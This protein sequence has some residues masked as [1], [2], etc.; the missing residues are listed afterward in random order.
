MNRINSTLRN[1]AVLITLVV[2]ALAVF[3]LVSRQTE[4]EPQ[5]IAQATAVVPTTSQPTPATVVPQS[6]TEPALSPMVEPTHTPFTPEVVTGK[7]TL[8]TPPP[9]PPTIGPGLLSNYQLE[10]IARLSVSDKKQ[11]FLGGW[12]ADSQNLFVY[13]IEEINDI[14]SQN[15]EGEQNTFVAL[16]PLKQGED[17]SI[18]T[19]STDLGPRVGWHSAFISRPV[20]QLGNLDYFVYREH[21]T[22]NQFKLWLSSFDGSQKELLAET[23]LPNFASS[24]DGYLAYINQNQ[25]HLLH[26]TQT[27]NDI[28]ATVSLGDIALEI[29]DRLFDIRLSAEGK[30]V[31]LYDSRVHLY[32]IDMHQQTVTNLSLDGDDTQVL[33][34]DWSPDGQTLAYTV[35]LNP[36][37]ISVSGAG[38]ILQEANGGNRRNIKYSSTS[39]N[40]PASIHDFEWSPDG[41]YLAAVVDPYQCT[42][43]RDLIIFISKNGEN[44]KEL[45]KVSDLANIKWVPNGSEISYL[46]TDDPYQL[47]QICISNVISE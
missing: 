3:W 6:T 11:V 32:T 29:N 42:D 24:I 17:I 46:C 30:Y 38:L 31:A 39:D 15:N 26:P 12:T 40:E 41:N 47:A 19:S 43:C 10:E 4:F 1:V 37:Q 22:D 5:T 34:A 13:R 2:L 44:I 21:R 23:D 33:D 16:L 20:E 14:E 18:Q 35:G 25:L 45:I 7:V 28:I 36:D 8:I 27:K 9:P